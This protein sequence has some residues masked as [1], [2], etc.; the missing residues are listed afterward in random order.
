MRM[1]RAEVG[2]PLGPRHLVLEPFERAAP[3]VFEP[4]A[5]RTTGRLF[6][7]KDGNTETIRDDRAGRFR[8]GDSVRHGR[9]LQRYERDDVD[10]SEARMH[11]LMSSKI[12]VRDG[13]LEERED[14]LLNRARGADKS[15]DGSVVSGIR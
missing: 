7:E 4:L 5:R 10:G 11:T 1:R 6:V 2:R 13:A 14:R 9:V 12:D 3:D 8:R 15:K